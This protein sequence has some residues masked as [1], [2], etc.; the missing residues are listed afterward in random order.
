MLGPPRPERQVQLAV[1]D[2]A[3]RAPEADPRPRPRRR[4]G[5][6]RGRRHRVNAPQQCEWTVVPP[7]HP[8]PRHSLHTHT[9]KHTPSIHLA[10]G[11]ALRS[12]PPEPARRLAE[13]LRAAAQS[14][15]PQPDH[16]CM[17]DGT[18]APF[19][20]GVRPQKQ[21]LGRCLRRLLR[22]HGLENKT[23]HLPKQG[24]Q[25]GQDTH[26]VQCAVPRAKSVVRPSLPSCR[27]WSWSW[28]WCD[29]GPGPGPGPGLVLVLSGPGLRSCQPVS[30]AASDCHPEPK[31][32]SMPV[33]R[34]A[35]EPTAASSSLLCTYVCQRPGAS[36]QTTRDRGLE[37]TRATRAQ[38]QGSRVRW[39]ARTPSSWPKSAK[40]AP[41]APGVRARAGV[42]VRSRLAASHRSSVWARY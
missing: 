7:G 19:H 41:V 10:P 29:P 20:A 6:R 13:A 3:P 8:P 18:L 40:S 22:G 30:P 26:A 15:G 38:G 12:I 5:R 1:Q 4:R 21:A 17:H 16:M 39:G 2:A 42:D 33:P 25:G 24:S 32:T 36:H 28:S 31:P 14:A 27:S 23:L 9:H 37:G 34:T 35:T 11:R